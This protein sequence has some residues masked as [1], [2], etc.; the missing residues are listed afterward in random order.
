M[1]QRMDFPDQIERCLTVL[2]CLQRWDFE[3]AQAVLAYAGSEND[4]LQEALHGLLQAM[5][6]RAREDQ[7][8]DQ[9]VRRINAGLLLDDILNS[10][11]EDFRDLIPYDR[12]GLSLIEDDGQTVRARWGRLDQGRMH[13]RRGY[14]APLAGSS[15]QSI[16]E[17]GQPRILNDLHDY[18]AQKPSSKSTR[19][20]VAEGMRSSL[21]CPL[22]ANGVPV[23]FLFFSSRG[24]NTYR[25]VHVE[26]FLRLADRLAIAVERGCLVSQLAAHKRALERHNHAL[27]QLNKQ[28]DLFLGIAAHDLRG[29]LSLVEMSSAILLDPHIEVSAHDRAILLQDMRT[30]ARH[31]MALIDDLLDVAVIEQGQ[32]PLHREMLNIWE[33]LSES[34]ERHHRLAHPRGVHVSLASDLEEGVVH[35]DPVRLRQV[36][37]NLIANA[38]RHSPLGGCVYLDAHCHDRVWRVSVIDEGPGIPL[39]DQ[40]KLFQPFVR[41]STHSPRGERSTGLGLAIARQVVEAHGGHIGVESVPGRGATFWFTLPV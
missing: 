18:L 28:K 13:L 6:R 41:L 10:V 24:S 36:L 19:L 20:I 1:Q 38:V 30:Q 22:I 4:P 7:R 2:A 33:V 5:L 34:A 37:D 27:N 9:L 21:T 39:E 40:P 26:T 23:G 12:L 16:L 31:M 17:T 8:I 29:P 11:Y 15:L 32:L 3:G 25:D 14:A 35:A